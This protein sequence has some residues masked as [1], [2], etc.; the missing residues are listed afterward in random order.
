MSEWTAQEDRRIDVLLY[1]II[2]YICKE[3]NN[4]E[5]N[6]IVYYNGYQSC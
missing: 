4:E 5:F 1:N 2:L 3:S 6:R